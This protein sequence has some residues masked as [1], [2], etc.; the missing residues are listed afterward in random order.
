MP[1]ESATHWPTNKVLNRSTQHELAVALFALSAITRA[2]LT[3]LSDRSESARVTREPQHA[4]DFT[5][6]D[7]IPGKSIVLLNRAIH[8][9]Q[10]QLLINGCR[11]LSAI[12]MSAAAIPRGALGQATSRVASSTTLSN[13]ISVT[14]TADHSP[15]R[16]RFITVNGARLEVLDWGGSGPV[17]LFL[18]GFGTGAHIFDDIAPAF[19]DRFHVLALTPRGFLPS[20]A[21]DSGYTIAQLAA[22]VSG[23][24]DSIGARRAV[25]AGHSIS[26]AVI[27]RFGDVYPERLI[28]AIYL[29]A[30]FDFGAVYRNKSVNPIQR[31]PSTV[32]TTTPHYRAWVRRYDTPSRAGDTDARITAHMWTTDSADASR[33]QALVNQ[34]ATEVRSRPHEFWHVQAPALSICAI[35]SLGRAYG[36]L[37][38]D[39]ARWNAAVEY[40]S[41][42][43][44]KQRAR[45][46]E[47]TRKMPHGQ[48]VG[49][50]SGH[51]VFIDRR[52]AVIRI[53]RKFLSG[54]RI[55]NAHLPPNPTAEDHESAAY[56]QVWMHEIQPKLAHFSTRGRQIIIPPTS[57]PSHERGRTRGDR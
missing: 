18:P 16:E 13:T 14:D 2:T 31:V 11:I 33:R 47:F 5:R 22:D 41:K 12:A 42:A 9:H 23:V 8:N 15:H 53:M 48:A 26:G 52:D 34:L 50:T 21:P 32:D 38:P 40:A 54:Q 35:S 37:T 55:I 39:S 10:Y 7:P 56:E 43:V 45:C 19:T 30:A 17:L 25:F 20:S 46:A 6:R 4:A 51:F 27:T 24:L 44:P 28:A 57:G 29:D 3:G 49:L 36:W 1:T